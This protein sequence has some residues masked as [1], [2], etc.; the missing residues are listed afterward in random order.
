[1]LARYKNSLTDLDAWLCQHS[2]TLTGA[3][4]LWT[5]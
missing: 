2:A 3:P 5:L 1:L 4:T